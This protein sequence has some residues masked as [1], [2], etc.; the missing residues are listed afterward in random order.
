MCQRLGIA[1]L[2]VF[3]LGAVAQG[4]VQKLKVS[5]APLTSKQLAIYRVVLV[6][7]LKGSGRVLNLANITEPFDEPD[8]ACVPGLDSRVAKRSASTVHRIASSFVAGT[9]I[10]LV[11]SSRQQATIKESDPQNLM[12]KAL[13]DHQ[14]I[15][16]EQLDQS[17]KSAFDTGLF[18]LSEIAFDREHRRAVLSYS[19]V[20]GRL[21]GNGNTLVLRK[22][23]HNWKVLKRRGGWVS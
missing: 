10:T 9:K 22:V 8:T 20:C 3:S 2:V 6:N 21:C 11:D 15:T 19:F 17:V 16:D 4:T 13:D 7:Y 18:T 12:R 14:K 1:F 5:D 23:R